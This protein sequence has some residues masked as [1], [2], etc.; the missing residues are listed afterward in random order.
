M[1]YVRFSEK[2]HVY[3]FASVNGGLECCGCWLEDTDWLYYS[4]DDMIAHLKAHEAAG[5]QV[6]AYAYEGLEED[7]EENDKWLAE[8]RAK[9]GKS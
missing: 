8:E 2:S 9:V 6:P 1:S 5:H 7:R 4:T 3:V